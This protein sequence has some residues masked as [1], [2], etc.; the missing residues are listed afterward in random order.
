MNKNHCII[1]EN[2]IH[3]EICNF[4]DFPYFTA[5]VKYQQKKEILQK[6]KSSDIESE[7]SY[8]ACGYCGHIYIK[9]MPGGEIQLIS[10]GPQDIYL[11]GNPQI[12][13]FKR[14]LNWINTEIIKL[15]F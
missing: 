10:I 2:L 14:I 9:N 5:P 11:I 12:T 3:D 15:I 7:L 4:G 8:M 1:C 13:F 6:F